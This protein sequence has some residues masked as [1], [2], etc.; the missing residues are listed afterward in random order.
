VLPLASGAS[1]VVTTATSKYQVGGF[2]VHGS[3]V[4]NFARIALAAQQDGSKGEISSNLWRKLRRPPSAA[5]KPQQSTSAIF[6]CL[7]N[8]DLPADQSLKSPILTLTLSA[9]SFL[10]VIIKDEFSGGPL[11]IMETYRNHTG[12]YR[13][14]TENVGGRVCHISVGPLM[15]QFPCARAEGGDGKRCSAM[16]ETVVLP[17]PEPIELVAEVELAV[18]MHADG[19]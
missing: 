12:I 2:S 6:P 8:L 16:P 3:T 18:C 10:D 7:R 19:R 9:P 14:K 15:Q 11:Y 1:G 17:N 4:F 13:C 5:P